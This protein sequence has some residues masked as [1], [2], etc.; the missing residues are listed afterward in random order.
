MNLSLINSIQAFHEKDFEK[1][2]VKV[3]DFFLTK[4]GVAA[5]SQTPSLEGDWMEK[6][7][8]PIFLLSSIKR[9]K[10]EL[11]LGYL[12]QLLWQFFPTRTLIQEIARIDCDQYLPHFTESIDEAFEFLLGEE[13]LDVFVDGCK[14]GFIE[15]STPAWP[16][17]FVIC[18]DEEF[19][20]YLEEFQLEDYLAIRIRNAIRQ[21]MALRPPDYIELIASHHFVRFAQLTIRDFFS[22][23]RVSEFIKRR[24]E[25]AQKYHPDWCRIVSVSIHRWSQTTETEDLEAILLAITFNK[26]KVKNAIVW[27]QQLATAIGDANISIL[28]DFPI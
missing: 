18:I 16:F 6:N 8:Y 12:V 3:N 2:L 20:E 21:G 25:F 7:D 24:V 5:F 1:S 26:L 27:L 19:E 22:Q 28:P 13:I 15:T 10:S 11:P 4:Y 9:G 14:T 17:G 23:N